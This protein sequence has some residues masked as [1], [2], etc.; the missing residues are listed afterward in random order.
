MTSDSGIDLRGKSLIVL[1][2]GDIAAIDAETELTTWGSDT[3]PG[4]LQTKAHVSLLVITVSADSAAVGSTGFI[5]RLRGTGF[6]Q[7]D[8]PVGAGGGTLATSGVDSGFVVAAKVDF[9]ID[10]R[11][12]F[13]GEMVG[14]DTGTARMTIA[15]Y[16]G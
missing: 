16:G 4:A 1:R 12:R 11:V 14:V 8:I 6:T 13:F 5:A 9:D 3:A 2:E 15:A 7:L 10:G